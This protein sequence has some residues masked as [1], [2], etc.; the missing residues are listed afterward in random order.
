M[1]TLP[2]ISARL[3]INRGLSGLIS[4]LYRRPDI[5][6]QG[7]DLRTGRFRPCRETTGL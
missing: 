2:G 7:L 1:L 4:T 6:L 3:L 5:L